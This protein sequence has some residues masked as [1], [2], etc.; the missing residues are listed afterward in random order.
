MSGRILLAV[1]CAVSIAIWAEP[2]G[3][4]SDPGRPARNTSVRAA[5]ATGTASISGQVLTADTGRPVKRARVLATASDPPLTRAVTTDE[6]GLYQ[7]DELPAGSYTL[8]VSKTGFVDVSYGQ[9]RPLGPGVRLP[10][11]DGQQAQRIDFRLPRGSVITG[12]IFDQD[13]EPLMRT[14][15]RALRFQYVQGERRLVQAGSDDTDDRGQFRIYGLP[16]GTYYVS[17]VLRTGDGS[18][19]F[20]GGRGGQAPED[21]QGRGYAPTYYPGVTS[22][23]EALPILVGLSQEAANIEF[24]LQLVTTARVSGTLVGPDGSEATNGVV[25]MTPDDGTGQFALGPNYTGRVQDAG[26][27]ALSGIPLDAT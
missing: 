18:P 22:T 4:Q 7:I 27:F 16:P 14:S 10:L 3:A 12:H 8:I 19:R 15:V 26:A 5:P 25:M 17:A 24:S 11:G 21:A 6:G 20:R 9:R 1:S 2:A 13:G 23:S